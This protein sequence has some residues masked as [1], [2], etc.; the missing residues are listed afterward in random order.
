M[1]G[2]LKQRQP[3]VN[4]DDEGRSAH[5]D[6]LAVLDEHADAEPLDLAGE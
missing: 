1:S 4:Q 3:Q 2:Q 5:Y 6:P